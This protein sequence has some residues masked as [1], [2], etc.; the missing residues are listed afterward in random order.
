MAGRRLRGQHPESRQLG[1]GREEHDLEAEH[2]QAKPDRGRLLGRVARVRTRH[3][4]GGGAKGERQGRGNCH[5]GMIASQRVFGRR[6]SQL[7][8]AGRACPRSGPSK[9]HD[10]DDRIRGC[11]RRK[12]TG[13][14][15]TD[16]SPVRRSDWATEPLV[17]PVNSRAQ[18]P[19]RT[20]GKSA[21]PQFGQRNRPGYDLR[22]QCSSDRPEMIVKAED[23]T[24]RQSVEYQHR[25]QVAKIEPTENTLH[26]L[27]PSQGI[28]YH[29]GR[30]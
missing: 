25:D 7:R 29:L 10:L 18:Q 16:H 30:R 28:V 9:N 8:S 23:A 4:V 17:L 26:W 14:L 13:P 24:V 6:S 12:L 27:E 2:Q 3:S 15:A 21:T 22:L 11:G 5:A 20:P 1:A 19:S